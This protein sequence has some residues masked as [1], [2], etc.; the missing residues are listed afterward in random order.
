MQRHSPPVSWRARI[1]RA[2]LLL[3]ALAVG[4]HL[5][6]TLLTPLLP[7]LLVLL[8]VGM[9]GLAVLHRRTS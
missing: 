2:A 4:I 8:V 3:I 6:D 1:L 9:V 5:I 7:D